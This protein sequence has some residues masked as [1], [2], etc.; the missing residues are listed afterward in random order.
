MKGV[1]LRHNL[2]LLA[3]PTTYLGVAML[4]FIYCTLAYLLVTDRQ[5]AEQDA[6]TRGENLVHILSENLSNV[7]DNVELSL[8]FLRASYES[9]GPAFNIADWAS[10]IASRSQY[11]VDFVIARTDGEV[12]HATNP[13]YDAGNIPGIL[14]A[15]RAHESSHGDKLEVGT[16]FKFGTGNQQKFI[17]SRVIYGSNTKPAG[18]VAAVVD[19]RELASSLTAIDLG[20]SGAFAL[21]GVNDGV[22]R[23]RVSDGQLDQQSIGRK[24][25]P[26]L[27]VAGHVAHAPSGALWNSPNGF[28]G[29]SR[30]L[31]YQS[32]QNLPLVAVVAMSRAEVYRR[33]DR[34]A[35]IYWSIV[36]ILT[37]T[38]VSGIAMAA[39]REQQLIE[40]TSD[41]KDAQ[42]ALRRSD[43]RYRKVESAVNDGIWDWNIATG[44]DYLSPR[45][46]IILGYA[47]HE[48]PNN[49][50]AFLDHV[51]PDDRAS[52]A[53]AAEAH[54]DE[55]EPY[56]VEYR[57]RRK[58]GDYI[59]VQSRGKAERDAAG[60]AVRMLGIMTDISER[61][62]VEE[63]LME[64]ARRRQEAQ[65]GLARANN[66][67][68]DRVAQRTTE[69]AREMCRRE[70]AQMKL[71]QIQKL[72]AVGQLTAGIA[73]DFNNLLSVVN[74]GLEFVRAAASRSLPADQGLIEAAMRATRRGID[75]V[76]RLLAFSRRAPLKA[77][78][79]GIDRLVLDAL[80][81]L[82]RTLGEDI[83][84]E[85]RLQATGAIVCVDRN[86]MI[87]VLVNLALN[88]RDAMPDGGKLTIATS[89]RKSRWAVEEGCERWPTGDA[90]WIMVSDTGAGMTDEVRSRAFEPFFT[91]KPDGLGTGLGLSTVL[92]FVEQTGGHIEIDSEV[93]FGTTI[94]IDLPRIESDAEA[95]DACFDYGLPDTVKGNAKRVLLVEDDP[96]VRIMTAA[97]LK[98]LGYSVQEV[99][100]GDEAITV[101]ESPTAID[102][103]VTDIVLP[104]GID[105]VT[106]V[107][108]ALRARPQMGVLCMS[109]YDPAQ[110]RRKWLRIQNI[111]LLEKPFT[112]SQLARALREAIVEKA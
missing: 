17:L 45:W 19:I 81:L 90:V 96:D 16:P 107:K 86:Q 59:W 88:A 31:T 64:E 3:Q 44:E 36:L 52:V 13:A 66:E 98:Q 2:R 97:Q 103:T 12:I 99:A 53:A 22:L 111:G 33:A 40:A 1:N 9:H 70:D 14:E 89:C 23:L 6:A 102:I 69:L 47:D 84:I 106:L 34:N 10:N 87:N 78:P 60:R 75:L 5:A 85:T 100:N 63:A 108:E 74:G 110:S 20:P 39:R 42:A 109:G 76:Q 68:E 58:K 21:S 92:G 32:L 43:E 15:I 26:N 51:H 95:F 67:L 73:H 48:I 91:T 56:D 49:R 93:G 55:N 112:S 27:N 71:S 62:R 61:K 25:P 46:K 77:E 4:V 104:G 35:E 83:E 11:S 72:E 41:M 8:R 54:L 94:T 18:I 79:A 29:V 24:L 80:Q 82:H 38:I 57:L 28:D 30:R 7:F 101:I 50:L 37:A 65:D 105:G